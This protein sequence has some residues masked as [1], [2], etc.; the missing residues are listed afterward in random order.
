MI[1][2]LHTDSL[3]LDRVHRVPGR[4]T[5]QDALNLIPY[6]RDLGVNCVE[7]MPMAEFQD[8]AGWGYSTSHYSPSNTPAAGGTSSNTS[9]ANATATASP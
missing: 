6:L 4:G 8:R 7:L 3:G 1:Y 9:S 2:E 5:L